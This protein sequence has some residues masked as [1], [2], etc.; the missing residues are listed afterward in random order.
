ME[1]LEF[2]LLA[3]T[4]PRGF[5]EQKS[6]ILCSELLLEI[7]FWSWFSRAPKSYQAV[8]Q[9][10]GWMQGLKLECMFKYTLRLSLK[11]KHMLKY[12]LRLSQSPEERTGCRCRSAGPRRTQTH[13]FRC[14]EE[15]ERTIACER[16]C[17]EQGPSSGVWAEQ[18]S[19]KGRST[20][21]CLSKLE[22]CCR[23]RVWNPHSF[24]CCFPKHLPVSQ[25]QTHQTPRLQWKRSSVLEWQAMHRQIFVQGIKSAGTGT[26]RLSDGR[27][28]EEL[29]FSKIK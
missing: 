24:S 13:T 20:S 9:T 8:C 17:L 5:S 10:W 6:P 12:T 15:T 7:S 2:S 25:P 4:T 3:E 23:S 26:H 1:G 28:K 22:S 21:T 11:L 16:R 29:A 27:G 18:I 19:A 14:W